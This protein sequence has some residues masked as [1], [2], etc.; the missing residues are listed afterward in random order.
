[1]FAVGH[2]TRSEDYKPWP[3]RRKLWWYRKR[4]NASPSRVS[5]PGY[6]H[7]VQV[8]Q[9]TKY[10]CWIFSK[11]CAFLSEIN[12]RYE[13]QKS[14]QILRKVVLL[15][16][17]LYRH[18]IKHVYKFLSMAFLTFQIYEHLILFPFNFQLIVGVFIHLLSCLFICHIFFFLFFGLFIYP[19]SVTATIKQPYLIP[20]VN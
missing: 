20:R 16:Q 6:P 12:L 7:Q 10:C 18:K 3:K 5:V 4:K 13:E 8:R 9:K 2:V 14:K 11:F 15:K 1:M 19:W 17:F